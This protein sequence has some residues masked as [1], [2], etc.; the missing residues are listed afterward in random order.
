MFQPVQDLLKGQLSTRDLPA[1]RPRYAC[2]AK[3]GHGGPDTPHNGANHER[4]WLR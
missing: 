3:T 4:A 2:G 1:L